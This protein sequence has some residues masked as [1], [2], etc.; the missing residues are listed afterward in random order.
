MVDVFQINMQAA[1]FF[2]VALILL[3]LTYIAFFK[4]DVDR[5][6]HSSSKR[7]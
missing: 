4:K 7:S 2:G 1:I 3:L 5:R 6:V